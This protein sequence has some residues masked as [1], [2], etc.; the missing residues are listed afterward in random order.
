MEITAPQLLA[1]VKTFLNVNGSVTWQ[2]EKQYGLPAGLLLAVGS[3]ETNL[4]TNV[5]WLGPG[6]GN[7][8]NTPSASGI[9]NPVPPTVANYAKL[10]AS[11]LKAD[12]AA[13]P[14]NTRAGVA[15]YNAGQAGVAA[16]IR[17]TGNP[18]SATTHGDYGSDVLQRLA[19]I[20]AAY[21]NDA[22]GSAGYGA[23]G[24]AA[25]GAGGPVKTP[26]AYLPHIDLKRRST[27]RVDSSEWRFPHNP[28]GNALAEAVLTD[29]TV[30]F[31]G[32]QLSEIQ[33][34]VVDPDLS[35]FGSLY[36]MISQKEGWVGLLARY[37][38]DVLAV[39]EV[40]STTVN[41]A[42]CCIITLQP[43]FM[44]WLS[45]QRKLRTWG[46][47]S[48]TG[49]LQDRV[50]EYNATLSSGDPKTGFFGEETATRGSITLN[51]TFSYYEWQSYYDLAM[52]LAL[53]E[54]YWLFE[55]CNGVYFG[56]P[57]WLRENVSTVLKVG[58]PGNQTG[59]WAEKKDVDTETIGPPVILRSNVLFTGDTMTVYLD[60]D[61]GEQVR[62]GMGIDLSGVPWAQSV[63]GGWIVQ[64][65]TYALD[66]GA[67]AV[68]VDCNQAKYVR[69]TEPG[70]IT[71]PSRTDP[72]GLSPAQ[73]KAAQT[74][75]Q[76][77]PGGATGQNFYDKAL[78]QVGVPYVYGGE[79]PG[80]GFDCSGLVQ[81]AAAQLGVSI[82][83]TSEMQWAACQ[84]AGTTIT[85][86]QARNIQGAL[87]FAAGSDGTVASPGH[88]AISTGDGSHILQAPYTGTDVQVT[89]LGSNW[90]YFTHAGL[91]PGV[92]YTSGGKS[93]NGL[94][95]PTPS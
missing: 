2:I 79:K 3:R 77:H 40:Q 93:G 47:L 49:W 61:I 71:R 90:S 46:G 38:K 48:A 86:D 69:G 78:T 94:P 51:T 65:V 64:N 17:S 56:E 81:W 41:D 88:V 45:T 80:T 44:A 20:Q 11:V 52:Q 70:G 37:Q 4:E 18:D 35:I 57:P 73:Q 7:W 84:A 5:D 75:A 87:V 66:G 60:R 10:A 59:R 24:S 15:A 26:P 54:G 82:A 21:P 89:N 27:G 25:A 31:Y 9:P 22:I 33:L 16:A 6:Y 58:W 29:S 63:A 8:Q 76:H 36:V 53:Q 68:Q 83:R 14:G 43:A 39:T 12:L 72:T 50:A 55:S 30:N 19:V 28:L 95:G 23:A 32:A 74:A 62:P 13:F 42:T 92:D 85:V 1:Q 34:T 91:I 67:T